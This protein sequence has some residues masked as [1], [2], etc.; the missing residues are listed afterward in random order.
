M[1]KE[2]LPEEIFSSL[3]Q[4]ERPIILLAKNPLPED[5]ACAY[6]LAHLLNECGKKTTLG[7]CEDVKCGVSLDFLPI[8][9]EVRHDLYGVQEMILLFNT[10]RNPIADIRTEQGDD[11]CKIFLTPERGS[12]DPR[13]FSFIPGSIEYDGIVTFGVSHKEALGELYIQNPDIFYEL[14]IVNIDC[15]KDNVL[16]GKENIV[17]TN[18][19]GVGEIV[20]HLLREHKGDL[21]ISQKTTQCFLASLILGSDNFQSPKTSSST[22]QL[23]TYLIDKGADREEIVR[24]IYKTHPLRIVKLLGKTLLNLR[25]NKEKEILWACITLKDFVESRSDPKDLLLILDRVRSYHLLAKHIILI[26]QREPETF[27]GILYSQN[28]EKYHK[29]SSSYPGAVQGRYYVF[30][31]KVPFSSRYIEDI[32]TLLKQ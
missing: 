21:P 18:V 24:H 4:F 10:K 15:N 31:K 2:S 14:P 26:F 22:F 32:E 12:L 1:E 16:Y 6:G 5:K 17:R 27:S 19:S 8:P 30:H 28:F 11:E 25:E 3:L 20:I 7:F 29:L 13:D 23:A 9:E